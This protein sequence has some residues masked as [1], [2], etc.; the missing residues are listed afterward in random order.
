VSTLRPD[1]YTL[2]VSLNGHS[3]RTVATVTGPSTGTT[4]VVHFPATRARAV[5]LTV[6]SSGSSAPPVLDELTV[7]G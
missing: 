7:T 1:R 3:W 4:D 2:A 6:T 5:A